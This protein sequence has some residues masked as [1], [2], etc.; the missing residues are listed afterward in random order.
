MTRPMELLFHTGES[1]FY[2]DGVLQ[3]EPEET[4][5][6]LL[7]QYDEDG[8][9]FLE[10][11]KRQREAAKDHVRNRWIRDTEPEFI[12]D[13]KRNYAHRTWANAEWSDI[14]LAIASDM[15]SPGELTTKKAVGH[16]YVGYQLPPD[17]ADKVQ[18]TNPRCRM[19]DKVIAMIMEHPHF[20]KDGL[21]L[22]IAGNSQI[23]LGRAGIKAAQD[24]GIRCSI[25]APKGFRMHYED[26]V[27]L[28]GREQFTDRFKEQYIDME[29]WQ[30]DEESFSW[31]L[32]DFNGFN[33][34]DM[35][36]FEIDLKIMHINARNRVK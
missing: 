2:R 3:E 5:E 30:K 7:K 20:R 18:Y 36:E 25:L 29:A 32:A 28:E 19:A 27:E 33:A 26:G 13:T 24:L 8:I 35:L 31:G 23:S 14:T 6:E 16:R 10:F 34:I 11:K 22:N 17:F 12:E 21:R 4:L 1:I 9:A 15:S